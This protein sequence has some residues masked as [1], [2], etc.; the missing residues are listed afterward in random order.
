LIDFLKTKYP[1]YDI[2]I[3]GSKNDCGKIKIDPADESG[4]VFDLC[5]KTDIKQLAAILSKSK[6]SVGA[7]TGPMH[8]SCVLG[9]PS[10]FIFGASD[11]KETAPYIGCFT[12]FFNEENPKDI[13]KISPKKVFEGIQKWIK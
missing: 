10:V 11:I 5:G 2:V 6:L 8:L 12:L 3:L 13:E 9:V 4:H 1:Q 7:D